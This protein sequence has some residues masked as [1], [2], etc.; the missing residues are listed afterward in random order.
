MLIFGNMVIVSV[1]KFGTLIRFMPACEV[2]PL[3]AASASCQAPSCNICCITNSAPAS[4]RPVEVALHRPM[5]C[6]P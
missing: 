2:S 1:P 4:R 3:S 6:G 5:L